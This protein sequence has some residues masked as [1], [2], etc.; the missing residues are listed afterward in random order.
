MFVEG[1]DRLS[2]PIDNL[3][4]RLNGPNIQEVSKGCYIVDVE[5]NIL[6]TSIKDEMD[7]HKIHRNTGIAVAAFTNLINVYKYGTGDEDDQSLLGCLILQ[8][9]RQE[10]IIVTQFGQVQDTNNILVSTVEAHYRMELTER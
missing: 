1:H 2:N 3:E 10:A 6:V 8:T 7:A 4:F 5:I 9:G